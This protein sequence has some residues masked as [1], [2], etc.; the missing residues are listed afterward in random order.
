MM[1]MGAMGTGMSGMMGG[2]A[3]SSGAGAGAGAATSGGGT[4]ASGGVGVAKDFASLLS[5]RS[6]GTAGALLSSSSG[7]TTTTPAVGGTGVPGNKGTAGVKGGVKG[8]AARPDADAPATTPEQAAADKEKP[9][10]S[11]FVVLFFWQEPTP[12]DKLMGFKDQLD[13]NFSNGGTAGGGMMGGGGGL[14]MGAGG[15]GL[16]GGMGAATK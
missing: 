8:G 7:T 1:G 3:A 4:S 9:Q 10:R 13:P 15:A 2:M 11:E 12:S 6:G 16:K 5:G 14:P